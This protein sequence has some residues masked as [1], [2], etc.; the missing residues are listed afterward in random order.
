MK[1]FSILIL[2]ALAMGALAVQAE[3]AK[4]NWAAK[5]AVCHGKEGKGDTKIGQKMGARDYSDAKVQASLTDD[6]IFAAI[7]D[8]YKK[9]DK[10]IMKGFA[11][12]MTEPEMKALVTFM[13]T[14]KAK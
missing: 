10:L 11:E 4:V 8:G 3:D 6:Q 2:A 13:R 14:L 1:R 12:K 5:C 7:K 9:D